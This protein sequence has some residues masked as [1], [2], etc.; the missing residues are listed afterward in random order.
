MPST[1]AEK[2]SG[3]TNMKRRRRKI[4]PIGPVT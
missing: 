2:I 4:C 1:S 3:I